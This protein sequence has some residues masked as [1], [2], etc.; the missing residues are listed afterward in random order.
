MKYYIS[1][2]NKSLVD[3]TRNIISE[4]FSPSETVPE[5]PKPKEDLKKFL[6][7]TPSAVPTTDEEIEKFAPL[8][9][10]R[11]NKRNSKTKSSKIIGTLAD[12]EE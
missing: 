8:V 7:Q 9:N 12:V 1:R 10:K 5:N 3:N 2:N 11:A 4:L 6:S